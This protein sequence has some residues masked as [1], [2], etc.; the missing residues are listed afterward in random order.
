MGARTFYML[1]TRN[2]FID[3]Q[4]FVGNNFFQN[5]SLSRLAEFGK[6]DTVN[7]YLTEITKNEIQNNIKEGLNIAE[8]EINKFREAISSKD[9]IL[10]QIIQL[11]KELATVDV[12]ELS[13][14]LIKRKQLK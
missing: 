3:T 6:L 4:T 12:S 2:L 14:R 13:Q 7:I 5:K 10:K 9:K 1:K 8:Q 11:T